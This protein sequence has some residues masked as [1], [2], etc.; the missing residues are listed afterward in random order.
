MGQ[1]DI[2]SMIVNNDVK[3]LQVF[4]SD[5]AGNEKQVSL[6]ANDINYLMNDK[7]W[8][9]ASDV[10]GLLNICEDEYL[11]KPDLKSFRLEGINGNGKKKAVFKCTVFEQNGSLHE[12]NIESTYSNLC[13]MAKER[14]IDEMEFFKI[15]F[16]NK[17]VL[18]IIKKINN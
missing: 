11:L 4:F 15:N 9:D 3:A 2:I 13:N 8:V 14:G 5:V 10:T 1:Q 18:P 7:V 12:L 16:N 6:E 17:K